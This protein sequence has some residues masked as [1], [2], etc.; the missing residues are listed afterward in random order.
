MLT[1]QTRSC[2]FQL[3]RLLK[4]VSN[5]PK[6]QKLVLNELIAKLTFRNENSLARNNPFYK[7]LLND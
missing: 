6:L 5:F 3:S 7:S 1:I 2:K 4:N